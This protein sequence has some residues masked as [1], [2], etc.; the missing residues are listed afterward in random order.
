M[1]M[2]DISQGLE[3]QP[4][5]LHSQRA[6]TSFQYIRDNEPS[7]SEIRLENSSGCTCSQSSSCQSGGCPCATPVVWTQ[8]GVQVAISVRHGAKSWTGYSD[9]DVPAG[10]FVCQYA[11]EILTNAVASSR[12]EEYDRSPESAGHALLVVREQ[13]PSRNAYLRLNIDA[14]RKGNVARFFSHR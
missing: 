6:L 10:S 13:L 12:L 2:M 14:T 7:A 4:V 9:N 8:Q 5:V 11:G 3:K 1:Q